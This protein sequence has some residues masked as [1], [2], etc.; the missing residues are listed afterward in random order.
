M[1]DPDFHQMT[2]EELAAW[3]AEN[4]MELNTFRIGEHLFLKGEDETFRPHTSWND[5]IRT[6]LAADAK[7]DLHGLGFEHEDIGWTVRT[8]TPKDL[9]RRTCIFT[10]VRICGVGG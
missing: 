4:V 1:S 9:L 5:A 3:A 7:F 8:G 2:G 6:M 10:S